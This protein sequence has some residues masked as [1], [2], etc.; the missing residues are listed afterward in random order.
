MDQPITRAE[1]KGLVKTEDEWAK[2]LMNEKIQKVMTKIVEEI[3]TLAKLGHT[4][5][6][7]DLT[8]KE[9]SLKINH[10]RKYFESVTNTDLPSC[11]ITTRDV[12]LK[13]KDVIVPP[14]NITPTIMEMLKAKFP[15]CTIMV[16]PFNTYIYIEWK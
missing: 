8:R 14:T 6:K 16:D 3:L 9:N 13:T 2:E 12:N 4:Y 7:Y 1:L 10:L 11:Y 15:D 5:Y